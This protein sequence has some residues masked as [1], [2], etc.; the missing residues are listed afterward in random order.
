MLFEYFRQILFLKFNGRG[1]RNIQFIVGLSVIIIAT[2]AAHAEN[3]KLILSSA[4]YV[5]Y[6]GESLDNQGVISEM[7]VVAFQRAGYEVKIEFFPWA[8][9]EHMAQKGECDGMFAL[10]YRPERESWFIYSDPVPPPNELVLFKSKDLHVTFNNYSDIKDFVIGYVHGYNYPEEFET[11]KLRKNRSYSD[12]ENIQK[13]VTGVASLIITDKL[14]AQFII[15]SKYSE[16]IGF[17]DAVIPAL[18]IDQQYLVI[19]KKIPDH[20]NVVKEFNNGLKQILA[21]GTAKRIRQ[22]HGF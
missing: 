4:D 9:A 21:D 13:L 1:M 3:R 11:A 12:E 5:P 18:K 10:W 16:K 7:I 14:Q 17:Y 19:S 22:N 8:R 6:F 20:D 15:N 2:I